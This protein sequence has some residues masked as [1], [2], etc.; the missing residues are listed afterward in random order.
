MPGMRME[1]KYTKRFR[2]QYHKAGKQIKAAFAQTVDLF[3]ADPQNPFLR[4]HALQD[5]F[6]G[7][8]SI[9]VTEDWRAVFKETK[10]GARTV[11]TFHLLGTHEELYG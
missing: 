6:A 8:R 3:W 7:Y 5:K 9:D 10:S 11:I 2:G 1:I 4:N